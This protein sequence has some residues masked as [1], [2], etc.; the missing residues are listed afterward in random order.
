MDINNITSI[1]S[2]KLLNQQKNCTQTHLILFFFMLLAEKFPE[3]FPK[4]TGY[5]LFQSFVL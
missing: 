2:S 1:K 3:I 5:F 4:H